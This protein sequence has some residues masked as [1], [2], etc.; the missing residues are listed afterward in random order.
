MSARSLLVIGLDGATFDLLE[1]WAAAGELP[2]FQHLLREGAWGRLR[3]VPNTDTAPAWVSFATGLGPANHGLFHELDWD[4][5]RRTLRPVRG[6]DRLG[7][8]I[9]GRASAAGRRVVAINVPFSYP[10]EPI[11]GVMIA[12][13]D[14]PG[15]RAPGLCQP[16]GFLQRLE[17]AAGPYRIDSAIS[18][19]IKSGQPDVGLASAYAVAA[20]HTAAL[21]LALADGPCDLAILVYSVPDEMQHFFWRQMRAGRGPQRHAIRDGYRF[22]DRTLG[23]LLAE[24]GPGTTLIVFSDHGFGPICATPELLAGWLRAH[25]FLRDLPPARRPWPQQIAQGAY[26]VLRQTLGEPAKQA[27]RRAL[28]ALRDRVESDVRFAGI[29]WSASR[30]FVGSSPWEIWINT[31]GR[32]PNGTVNPGPEYDRVC[33]ELL[34]ALRAWRDPQGRPRVRAAYRREEVYTGQLLHL[35]P[36]ITIEWDVAA[37]PDP[38]SLPGNMSRFDADHQPEGVLL[39]YGPGIAPGRHIQGARLVDLAPTIMHLLGIADGLPSDG[40]V[41]TE[42]FR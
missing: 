29:D 23:E 33:D 34:A 40:R 41:L 16:P 10:A 12:G 26:G 14:A 32:E 15:P 5:G 42:I 21:R 6:G 4:A 18:Q 1:P 30:A 11:N 17:R 3:T 39:A 20:L 25:G 31:R 2:T 7:A 22:I 28:P 35:A 37:A 8:A 27:L 38:E 36:D 19:A 13:I 9:W 24:R